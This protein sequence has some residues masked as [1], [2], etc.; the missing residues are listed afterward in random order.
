MSNSY[1]IIFN[2]HYCDV[3]YSHELSDK[4]GRLISNI[5]FRTGEYSVQSQVSKENFDIF[6]EF[7]N[8]EEKYPD[9]NED[10]YYDF[11]LLSS[12][13]NNI[14]KD[15]LLEN[16]KYEKRSIL[17]NAIKSDINDKS[18]IEEFIA[19]NLDEY[20]ESYE[21]EMSKVPCQTLHKIFNHKDRILNNQERAYNF[22]LKNIDTNN[23]KE[24]FCVLLESLDAEK[25]NE[26][27]FQ[28]SLLKKEEHFGFAP[29]FNISF[30]TSFN[31]CIH[32]LENKF[33]KAFHQQNQMMKEIY[34]LFLKQS[35]DTKSDINVLSEKI[36]S[37]E[38][39]MKQI[40]TDNTDVKS[41]IKEI[42]ANIKNV[43]GEISQIK[44]DNTE[45]KS[46]IKTLST[47]IKNV[48][49]KINQ[50]NSDNTE[51]KSDIN[52]LSEKIK[53]IEDEMKQI[54]TDNT[55]VKS[56]IKSISTNIK[57]IEGEISQ[58]QT[59]N[60]GVKRDIRDLSTNIK[61]VDSEMKQ[62]QT[63]NGLIQTNIQTITGS[64]DSIKSEVKTMSEANNES[65]ANIQSNIVSI[66]EIK[67]KVASVTAEISDIKR[68]N[69]QIS[70]KCD[71]VNDYVKQLP[72]KI[73]DISSINK[74][75]FDKVCENLSISH[76]SIGSFRGIIRQLTE[77]CGGNVYDKGVVG[78]S[79][80]STLS[81]DYYI[82]KGIVDLDNTE[83]GFGSYDIE[84]SWIA[85]DFK[86][87][88]VRPVCYLIRSTKFEKGDCH[89]MNWVIE[90]S[91]SG[92]SNDWTVLDSRNN[93]TSLDES[94]AVQIFSIQKTN[95][96]YRHLRIRQTGENSRGSYY[97]EISALEYFGSIQ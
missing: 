89:P 84:N 82:P 87:K 67:G 52:V 93:I 6:F 15:Y 36:K 22:I 3:E 55:D 14:L 64:V 50:V 20:L 79:C 17:Q 88:K 60:S 91:N 33:E 68:A 19:K 46:D 26:K 2:G 12:E 96:F 47:E 13:F 7:L 39:E 32:E 49:T 40:Q 53:S 86:Y 30:I 70:K 83:N 11:F 97:L 74:Q 95:E 41:D 25:I 16:E 10:N 9:I 27:S 80:S 72:N 61:S 18:Y 37:I 73:S 77:A 5:L 48:D 69:T 28:D 90:G 8:K 54:Q 71:D 94:N 23:N 58:I 24:S 21:Q 75:I 57:N 45:V 34:D 29:K 63:Q 35:N 4:L 59:D 1:N 51:I 44:T 56:D 38:N 42:S 43:E 92:S 85:Y 78:L 81:S 62:I 76:A 66:G 65:H 31:Q